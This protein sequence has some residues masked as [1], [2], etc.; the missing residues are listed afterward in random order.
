[1][2]DTAAFLKSFFDF[3]NQNAEYAVL[4]NFEAY[5]IAMTAVILILLSRRVR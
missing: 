2:M 4:R 3:L 5:L 1:M